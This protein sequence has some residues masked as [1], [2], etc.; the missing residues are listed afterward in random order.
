M[1]KSS[2][3]IE[4]TSQNQ[5]MFIEM[6]KKTPKRWTCYNNFGSW[7]MALM[8]RREVHQRAL[9]EMHQREVQRIVDS[10]NNA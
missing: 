7:I 5:A 8:H 2:T 3:K 9:Q 1:D 6:K 10:C 4:H